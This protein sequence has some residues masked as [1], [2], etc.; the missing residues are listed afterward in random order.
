MSCSLESFIGDPFLKQVRGY[1]WVDVVFY[2]QLEYLNF[3]K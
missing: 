2:V 3:E 1:A